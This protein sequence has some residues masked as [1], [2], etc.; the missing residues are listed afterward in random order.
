MLMPLNKE[1][2]LL[3]LMNVH[4]CIC[5]YQLTAGSKKLAQSSPKVDGDLTRIS[6]S[7]RLK[8]FLSYADEKAEISANRLKR[9]RMEMENP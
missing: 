6:H 5:F 8:K 4:M 3:W 1:E 9:K 7:V 2:L